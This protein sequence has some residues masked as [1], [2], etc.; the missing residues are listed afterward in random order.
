ME[1]GNNLYV[2]DESLR[3]MRKMKY[4]VSDR[5]EGLDQVSVIYDK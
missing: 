4:T 1:K 2:Y 5:V 3:E